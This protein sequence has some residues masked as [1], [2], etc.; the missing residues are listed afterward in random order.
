MWPLLCIF[1]IGLVQLVISCNAGNKSDT[2]TRIHFLRTSPYLWALKFNMCGAGIM[3][4]VEKC[5][6][7]NLS[8]C[9]VS[10]RP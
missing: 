7:A 3:P 8:G 9:T 6:L 10:A 1:L 2:H 5:F 4:S